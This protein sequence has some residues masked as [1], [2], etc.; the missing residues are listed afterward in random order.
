MRASSRL[1]GIFPPESRVQAVL[2][3]GIMIDTHKKGGAMTMV[4]VETE[5]INQDGVHVADTARTI[6]VRN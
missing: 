3:L 1:T 6:V 4:A 5:V 2:P